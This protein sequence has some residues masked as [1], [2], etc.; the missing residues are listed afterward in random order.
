VPG[1][2]TGQ[3]AK[4][5]R[6]AAGTAVKNGAFAIPVADAGLAYVFKDA[7]ANAGS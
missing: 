7:T 3:L 5:G 6:Q 2:D 4:A 1:K